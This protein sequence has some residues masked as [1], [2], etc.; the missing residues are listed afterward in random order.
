[1][2]VV[3]APARP[4]GEPGPRAD[5]RRLGPAGAPRRRDLAG[6]ARLR[7]AAAGGLGAPALR[8]GR[9]FSGALV[10][11]AMALHAGH[12]PADL[13]LSAGAALLG[14]AALVPVV[15]A[16]SLPPLARL[17]GYVTDGQLLAL[18]NLNHPA[19]K[20]LIV[21]APG[22]YRHSIVVGALVE[23]AGSGHRR[24]SAAG[25]GRRLLPRPREDPDPAPLRREPAG[26]ERARRAGAGH[27][28]HRHQAPRR[29]RAGGGDA[30]AAPG[31]GPR[32]HRAAPRDP[33]GRRTSGPS[34]SGWPRPA[35]RRPTRP[36]SATRGP[37]PQT[38]EVAL[39]MLADACEASAHLAERT[40]AEGLRA[41]V[42]QR[43]AEIVAEGQL[44]Q[45]ELTQRD[46]AL[47]AEAMTRALQAHL[48]SR[49]ERPPRATRRRARRHP[50]GA[51]RRDRQPQQPSA[52][53]TPRLAGWPATARR[54]LRALGRAR[55]RA[56]SILV[57]TDG[58]IRGLNR[59]WRA[60]DKA[61]DVLSFPFSDPP[62]SG[63]YLGDVVV[64]L[65]TASSPGTRGAAAA[66]RR[67]GSVPRPRP[68]PP[69]RLRS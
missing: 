44:D 38:R 58:V 51:G 55:G 15:V 35:D 5:R 66:G 39:V 52:G 61:T 67:A 60:M 6:G 7:G 21:Q 53:R 45:C 19:L 64:S 63:P 41:L 4:G 9:R 65:D 24:R 22:T 3:G 14:R 30:L 31:R 43:F 2:H 68:P 28:R 46:L 32:L 56:L 48:Q 23:E 42:D 59:R 54:Y 17:L 27:E 37:R 50:P 1:M 33:A 10:A 69:A 20:E 12:G 26:P 40:S 29:R 36:P 49:P 11:A 16:T 18:A 8:R 47:A 34:S 13:L 25:P 62:G 57:V